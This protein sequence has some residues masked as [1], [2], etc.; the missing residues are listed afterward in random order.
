METRTL[1]HPRGTRSVTEFGTFWNNYDLVLEHGQ[2]S[3]L[4]LS[5]LADASARAGGHS[6]SDSLKQL[7]GG[8]REE[9]QPRVNDARI[10]YLEERL[11][12]ARRR[13]RT[14]FYGAARPKR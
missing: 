2:L 6:F 4:E 3:A 8:L 9:I 14:A 1:A 10:A 11:G 12:V 7:V 13:F 5:T